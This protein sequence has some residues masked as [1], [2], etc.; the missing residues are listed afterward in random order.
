MRAAI[1]R[2]SLLRAAILFAQIIMF[3]SNLGTRIETRPHVLVWRW[4]WLR[5]LRSCHSWWCEVTIFIL[6]I[7]PKCASQTST[8]HRFNFIQST[9]LYL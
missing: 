2:S 7:S 1:S 4:K 6:Y 8:N 3:H 9:G 5:K